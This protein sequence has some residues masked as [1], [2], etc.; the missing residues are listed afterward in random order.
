MRFAAPVMAATPSCATKIG[1]G[2]ADTQ[3]L[4]ITA[5]NMLYRVRLK[6]PGIR[7]GPIP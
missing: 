6:T 3:G 5:Y 2:N 4:Y 7:P 1:F